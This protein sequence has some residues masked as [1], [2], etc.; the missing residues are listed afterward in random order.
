[1]CLGSCSET[2]R[3]ALDVYVEFKSCRTASSFSKKRQIKLE[4]WV[5]IRMRY[6]VQSATHG[7]ARRAVCTLRSASRGLR[8]A[9]CSPHP[10]AHA[11]ACACVC[12]LCTW[13]PRSGAL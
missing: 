4:V 10:A 13:R 1:M 6:R 12:A 2:L 3:S 8:S 11:A 5:L 7:A 9:T